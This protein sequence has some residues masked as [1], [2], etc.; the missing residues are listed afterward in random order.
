[1][2]ITPP[3][4]LLQKLE[5]LKHRHFSGILDDIHVRV[6]A[7]KAGEEWALLAG[8]ELTRVC[9][10]KTAQK[11][12]S[13]H[14]GIPEENIMLFATHTHAAP[15]TTL[16]DHAGDDV[17]EEAM[18]AAEEYA[19][20]VQKQTLLAVD[21]ALAEMVPARIGFAW[22]ESHI[23]VRRNQKYAVKI[24]E[25]REFTVV[26]LGADYAAPA[27][28]RLF[29]LKAESCEGKPIAF[30][31]NYSVHNVATIWNDFTGDQ[32][33]RISSD[34]GG[35]VSRYLEE[36]YPGSVAIWSSGAAGDL[37]PLLANEDVHPDPHTGFPVE[38]P[39]IGRET[40][41]LFLREMSARHYADIKRA[42]SKICESMNFG[43]IRAKMGW[44]TGP[45]CR[46]DGGKEGG[47]S[48]ELFALRVQLLRIGALA[49][50]GVSGEL[51]SSFSEVIRKTAPVDD[52]VI[53]NHVCMGLNECQYVL[54]DETLR[55]A[56]NSSGYAAVPG[57]GGLHN[58]AGYVA[59]EL[60][61][62][63]EKLFDET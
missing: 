51:Y 4:T 12:L 17:S 47:S 40:P 3:E 21:Q 19:A 44:L 42:I 39:V 61:S 18:A 11:M 28:P 25:G 54:D 35:A 56:E 13:E 1:M 37:N 23:N 16:P 57:Y 20:F 32:K 41:M 26:G 60:R 62:I 33:M 52:V 53:L 7:M 63:T 50:Y 34:I 27:D 46:G 30:L 10:P 5:G 2:V 6:L 45:G 55:W 15:C 14:T 58:T 49:F 8:Y 36:D 29:V 48:R 38:M 9:R 43:R 31:V 59:D 24:E 22:E